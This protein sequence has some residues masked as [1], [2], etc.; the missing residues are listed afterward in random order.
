M[1]MTQ[2]APTTVPVNE[3]PDDPVAAVRA[4]LEEN[5]DPDLTVADWWQ[6]LG[7]AGWS[8]PMLPNDAFGRGLSRSDSVAVMREIGRF[9]A[10]GPPAGL[11]LLLAAPTIATHGTPEQ[12]AEH[13]RDIVTG[14]QAWCQLFS[15]PGAGLR[16]RG[17]HHPRRAG[18]RGVRRQWA[19]G[20]DL[21]RP[22]RR[23][24]HV[25]R[26]HQR[27]RPEAPGHLVDGDR[28]APAGRRDPATA[29]DDRPCDVQRGVPHR[30]TGPHRRR[31]RRSPTMVGPSP[32]RPCR[33]NGPASAPAG[34]AAPPVPSPARWRSNSNGAP[35]T[36]WRRSTRSGRPSGPP[37]R[38]G[39]TTTCWSTSLARRASSTTRRSART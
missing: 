8:S 13:V 2:D 36:S 29:R 27:R 30:C 12:I 21:A 6:R 37:R 34:R 3:T 24:G 10:L 28:H 20:V 17:A 16:P 35:A 19:E 1:A 18:R 11:G 9:G 25:D 4:W 14:R 5:W 22:H 32:T 23:H 15:E 7:L 38:T 26:A 39:P 33:P 31:D